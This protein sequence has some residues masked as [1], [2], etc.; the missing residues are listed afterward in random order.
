MALALLP[1]A[2]LPLLRRRR[3]SLAIPWIGWL[4]QDGVG[5]LVQ[6]LWQCL[7]ILLMAFIVLGI[8]RPGQSEAYIERIG[9]GA[10][11]SILMD[12][13]SSMDA[14]IRRNA[15]K[16]GEQAQPTRS[17]NDE[18]RKALSWLLNQRP[19]IATR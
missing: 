12:R 8:A 17:K 7:A 9:R 10:E 13:S 19:K 3:D 1:L 15:P 18:A 6:R 14:F 2:L 11:I 5:R 16:L 4:P